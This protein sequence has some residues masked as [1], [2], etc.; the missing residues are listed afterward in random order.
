M[1]DG[2]NCVRCN[3]RFKFEEL[4]Y[5]SSGMGR[6]SDCYAKTNPVNEPRRSCPHDNQQMNKELVYDQVL[7]DRCPS[8]GG[9]WLDGDELEIMKSIIEQQGRNSYLYFLPIIIGG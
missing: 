1:F 6:C 7:I 9:V 2:E 8:C 3:K 4:A 5:S